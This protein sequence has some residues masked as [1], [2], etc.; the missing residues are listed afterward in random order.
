MTVFSGVSSGMLSF[1]SFIR[2]PF[3]QPVQLPQRSLAS[4]RKHLFVIRILPRLSTALK[5]VETKRLTRKLAAVIQVDL[6]SA[7][8]DN[9]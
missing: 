8:A 3:Q 7:P 2:P 1:G 4:R 9:V 5:R 6:H